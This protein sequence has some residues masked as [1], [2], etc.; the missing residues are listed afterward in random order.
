MPRIAIVAALE[1]EVR[2]L[3]RSWRV[4]ERRHEG[5]SFRFFENDKDD[6]VLVCGGMG[7]EAARRAAEAV[8]AI[9]GARMIYSA[10]FA[11]ALDSSLK[12]GEVVEPRRVVNASDGSSVSL[13]AGHGVLVSFAA[14]A[15]PAQKAKLRDAFAAEVV[16]ME[17]AAVARAAEARG[18][19]FAAVKAI[20][21]DSAFTFPA[22]ERFV[23]SDGQFLETRFM[24]FAAV[25]PWLWPRVARLAGN[26][27]RA[28]R[29]LC[30][31]LQKISLN[32]VPASGETCEAVHHQ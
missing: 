18:V 12:V 17:A 23:D 2:P 5:R 3:I 9:Y 27:R 19:G 8:I 21:D 32:P 6:V 26:S 20:S 13:A 1:R 28:S 4:S 29:A 30:D 11:G 22:L 25:R 10:G 7:A 24:L 31:R 15:S 16:D 14:V